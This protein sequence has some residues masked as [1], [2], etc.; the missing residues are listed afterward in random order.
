[1]RVYWE[2]ELVQ[3]VLLL[4][5]KSL[6]TKVHVFCLD[7]AT[8]MLA[9]VIHSRWT[10]EALAKK[11]EMVVFIIESVLKIIKEPS[12]RIEVSVLMHLLITLSYLCRERF[13]KQL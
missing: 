11:P 12:E 13:K 8:A 6:N 4:V 9:N 3:W 2:N 5:K 1:M 7:F 10:Q